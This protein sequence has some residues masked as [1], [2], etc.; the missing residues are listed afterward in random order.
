MAVDFNEVYFSDGSGDDSEFFEYYKFVVEVYDS[1]TGYLGKIEQDLRSG[2]EFYF[3]ENLL[4]NP[5]LEKVES[6]DVN[7]MKYLVE[8][9]YQC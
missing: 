7:E 8:R 6:L 2:E 9:A 3:C 5:N 1:E 4:E